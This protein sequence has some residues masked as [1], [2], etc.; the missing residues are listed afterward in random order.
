M[1]TMVDVALLGP[2]IMLL[3][4]V[5][6]EFEQSAGPLASTQEQLGFLFP[7]SQSFLA[8]SSLPKAFMLYFNR[9]REA[10]L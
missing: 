10:I 5:V 8:P 3:L 7:V 2:Q 9:V 6:L 4:R 1:F